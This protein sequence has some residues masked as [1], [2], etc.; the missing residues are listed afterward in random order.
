MHACDHAFIRSSSNDLQLQLLLLSYQAK[1][2]SRDIRSHF[3]CFVSLCMMT[4]L[5]SYLPEDKARMPLASSRIHRENLLE[6]TVERPPFRF[7]QLTLQRLPPEHPLAR[8]DAI[9]RI[10]RCHQRGGGPE[11]NHDASRAL[12]PESGP[13]LGSHNAFS[14]MLSLQF[15]STS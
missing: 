4:P 14:R 8:I 3:I 2:Q 7:Q 15:A 11:A 6:G 13:H 1:K 12:S 5:A 9:I 10:G